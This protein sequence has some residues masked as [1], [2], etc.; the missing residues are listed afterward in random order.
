MT[1]K[2]TEALSAETVKQAERREKMR[3]IAVPST[4]LPQTDTVSTLP[5]P[6]SVT[7]PNYLSGVPVSFSSGQADRRRSFASA[8]E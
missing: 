8:A 4:S 7:A 1:R 6:F 2:V 5:E 3:R